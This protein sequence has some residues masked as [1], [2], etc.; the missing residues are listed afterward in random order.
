MQEL[1]AQL[2]GYFRGVWHRRWIGLVVA[3]LVMAIGVVVIYRMPD[4]YDA[5]ARVY[6]D[7]QSLLRPLMAGM[8]INTDPGYQISILSRILFSRPNL[9]KIIRKADLDTSSGQSASSLVDEVG[10]ALRIARA[11]GDNL[12]TVGFLYPDPRKAQDVVQAA[13]STFIEQSLGENKTGAAS[14]R[15]FLDAQISEYEGKLREAENRVQA[16]RLKNMALLG[17]QG[18]DYLS[19][20]ATVEDQVRDTQIEL[21]VAEETRDGLKQQMQQM[22]ER[23]EARNRGVATAPAISTAVPEVDGRIAALRSQIDELLRRYTEQHPD[24]VVAHRQLAQL[25]ERKQIVEARQ[26]EA[27]A[28]PREVMESADP[29]TQQLQVALN[30]AE[31]NVVAVKARLTQYQARI[32]QLRAAAE[33]VPK[34]DTEFSQLNRDYD[35]LKGQY[36]SLVQRRETANLTGKLEDAGVAEFRIIDPPRVTPRP[37]APNRLALL[38]G[39]LAAA[40]GSGIAVSFLVSQIWPTFHDGRAMREILNR[41]LLGMVSMVPNPAWKR[42]R[43]RSAVLFAG[44]VGSFL[45]L[46]VTALLITYMRTVAQ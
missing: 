33:A 43:I 38:L 35:I 5:S 46:N 10:N 21:R 8:A 13:L 40:L 32:A 20:V 30:D 2:I 29:V 4:K 16:F 44:A 18:R 39:L 22:Q 15:R 34:I 45:A 28:H 12:Y 3:W 1:I 24:V 14:A 25:Q 36:N 41:P 11:G 26:Q 7:T 31:S 6:V 23:R 37:V 9:E 27:A 19:Q 17:S 42:K